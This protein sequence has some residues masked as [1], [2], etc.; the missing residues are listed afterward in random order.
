MRFGQVQMRS[1]ENADSS[2]VDNSFSYRHGLSISAAQVAMIAQCYMHLSVRRAR[3]SVRFRWP[4]QARGE[5]P[6]GLLL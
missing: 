2:N 1:V 3:T 5:E 6:E 4:T